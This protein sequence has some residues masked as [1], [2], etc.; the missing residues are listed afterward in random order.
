[1]FSDIPTDSGSRLWHSESTQKPPLRAVF[2]A[3]ADAATVLKN[4][5]DQTATV[6]SG[7]FHQAKQVL[8]AV[9]RRVRRGGPPAKTPADARDAFH[10]HRMK[11]AQ[12]SRLIN[13][14]A[15]EIGA[16]LDL[17]LPRAPHVSAALADA[18]LEGGQPFLLPLNRLLGLIGAHEWHKKGVWIPALNDRIHV[19]FGVFSPIRGEYL[20]LLM[21]AAL[22]QGVQTALDLGTGSGV[23]AALLAKRGVPHIAA[24]DNNPRAIACARANICRLGYE[25]QITLEQTDLFPAGKADLIVCNPPW[26]PAK[27]TS[28]VETALY[29]PGHT[30]LQAFLNGAPRHLNEGGEIWLVMS[31][32]AELLHLRP[33]GFL[34][35]TF[36]QAGLRVAEILHTHPVHGKAADPA[37]PLAFARGRET[38]SLYRLTT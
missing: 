36:R 16:G 4:A 2:L 28:A 29:D 35:D 20:E 10:L 34:P 5:H 12:Q 32:L 38:V 11:Q 30:M 33:A 1:M 3:Q 6:W 9:K 31:D 15:V 21:R 27:P 19:P 14:L 22:P 7:D 8:A 26:L 37:D 13:M 24:T 23:L 18:L 17:D 25:R